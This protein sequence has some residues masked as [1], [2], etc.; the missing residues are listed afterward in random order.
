MQVG[1]LVRY[2]QGSLDMMGLIL[3]HCDDGD[4]LVFFASEKQRSTR[5]RVRCRPRYLEVISESR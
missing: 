2:R 4:Y 3:E 1:D 5:N